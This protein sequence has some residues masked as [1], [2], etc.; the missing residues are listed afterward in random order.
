L[1]RAGLYVF[2]KASNHALG[3]FYNEHRDRS[4]LLATE[5]SEE[6][7]VC[8]DR[9]REVVFDDGW[10][11]PNLLPPIARWMGA[12]GRVNFRAT[13][14]TK[15]AFDLTS[16]MPDLR[17]RPLT[18]EVLLN[19]ERLSHFCL[20]RQT[21]LNLQVSV[22]ASVA[23]A[24]SGQFELELRSDRTWK[25]RPTND[26]T[27]DDRDLSIAVCNVEVASGQ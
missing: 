17:E 3:P 18:I 10:Y 21:W 13:G 6:S 19:G 26:A 9:N 24:A 20:C 27:R 11:E 16:H 5:R 8:L 23:A 25:P 7:L 15:I 22:P 14:L 12:R 2:L 1:P 4:D